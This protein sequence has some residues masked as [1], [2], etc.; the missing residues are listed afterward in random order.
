MDEDRISQF[1]AEHPEL[2]SFDQ[3]EP[4]DDSGKWAKEASEK[5]SKATEKANQENTNQAH[6][7]AD[8]AHAM[9]AHHHKRVANEAAANEHEKQ[10]AAHFEKAQKLPPLHK[11]SKRELKELGYPTTEGT[12]R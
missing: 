2:F 1:A 4:R 10:S 5:A 12:V 7:R 3:N 8:A 9:A 11:F 6:M